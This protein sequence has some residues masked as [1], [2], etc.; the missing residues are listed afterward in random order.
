MNDISEFE[1]PRLLDRVSIYHFFDCNYEYW[2]KDFVN[3]WST[4]QRTHPCSSIKNG[5]NAGCMLALILDGMQKVAR[6]ICTNK[7]RY[8]TTEEFPDCLYVG[9]G[10][11]PKGESRL[12]G[13]CHLKKISIDTETSLITND[14]K[15]IYDDP[16]TGCNVSRDD[17]WVKSMNLLKNF[18]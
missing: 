12:C 5:K 2:Y 1:I 15:G 6:P 9:C 10:N 3:H 4:H 17:R 11:T 13:E 8:V 7:N 14:D 18:E 16:V